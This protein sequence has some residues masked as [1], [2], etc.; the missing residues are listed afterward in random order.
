MPFIVC[1]PSAIRYWYI[2]I[3]DLI[4]KPYT[5]S[6]DS[7][8]FEGRATKTGGKFINWLEN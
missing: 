5:K 8:W 4:G 3:R 6:Y 7:I 1:I 2:G